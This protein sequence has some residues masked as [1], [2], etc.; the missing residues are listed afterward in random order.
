MDVSR[1]S[2][3]E[4]SPDGLHACRCA[5]VV[6]LACAAA[7]AALHMGAAHGCCTWVLLVQLAAGMVHHAS[8]V[9]DV[10]EGQQARSG[11]VRCA[12]LACPPLVPC[13]CL[14]TPLAGTSHVQHP[15]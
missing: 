13:A 12:R 7:L 9:V 8:M 15:Q 2:W 4:M 3:H 14:A 11:L 1:L 10:P 5:A 6:L